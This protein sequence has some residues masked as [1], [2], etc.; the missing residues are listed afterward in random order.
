[1]DGRWRHDLGGPKA[2]QPR[3][4]TALT[5]APKDVLWVG[6]T[7]GVRRLQGD[8]WRSYGR[9]EGLPDVKVNA[10]LVDRQRRVWAATNNGAALLDSAHERW[11]SFASSS[12]AVSRTNRIYRLAEDA[13]GG[14][15]A[16]G[17]DG[18]SIF[19]AGAWGR[20][21]PSAWLPDGI[22]SRFLLHTSDGSLWFAVRGLGVRRRWHGRWTAYSSQAGLAADTVRDV[23]RLPNG[24]LLF[25]TLGGGISVYR[26]D[27]HPPQTY[28][29][30][31]PG[32]PP[33]R[34]ILCGSVFIVPFGGQDVLQDTPT[35]Q[36]QYAWRLDR[37]SWSPFALKTRARLANLVSGQHTFEVRGMDRDLNIDPSPAVHR[38]IVIRPWYREPWL[39]GLL[40]AAFLALA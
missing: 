16:S 15:W 2:L 6:T 14:I 23:L 19:R 24:D 3:H 25:A 9:R 29:G 35:D 18:V 13:R 4:V 7:R 31:R 1:H 22:Y 39:W 40:V 12:S 11:R 17:L 34:K 32:S 30:Q 27:R 21:P 10:L 28:V 5:V 20:L 8:R 37:E 33:P 38:F 36:L 26:P